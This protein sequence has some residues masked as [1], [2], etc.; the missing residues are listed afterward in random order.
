LLFTNGSMKSP[1]APLVYS[2]FGGPFMCW[3]LSSWVLCSSTSSCLARLVDRN[4]WKRGK[5]VGTP[6]RRSRRSGRCTLVFGYDV[7]LRPGC[8]LFVYIL[9]CVCRVTG[10]SDVRIPVQYNRMVYL[11]CNRVPNGRT[12]VVY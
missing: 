4:R 8:L 1:C 7:F 10:R 3:I 11:H 9:Y 2:I 6:E 5:R 12:H